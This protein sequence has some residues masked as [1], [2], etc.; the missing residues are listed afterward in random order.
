MIDKQTQ[1]ELRAR[2]NPDGSDLRRLQLYML[3]LLV[4]FDRI[5]RKNDID[6]WLEYGT[7]IGAARHGGFIPWDDDLDVTLLKKDRKKLIEA[8]RKDL[9]APYY[10]IDADSKE[11]D[12]RRWCKMR[13][14]N[15]LITRLV[16]NPSKK[17]ELIPKKEGIWLDIFYKI[18]GNSFLSFKVDAFYGRCFRRKNRLV[19]DGWFKHL[20]GV[21]LFPVAQLVAALARLYGK[22][23]LPGRLIN[24][25]GTD[26][27]S[28]RYIKDIYPLKD[29]EFEGHLFKAPNDTDHYLKVIYGNWDTVPEVKENHKITDIE[30]V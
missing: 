10:F 8:L 2:Y 30:V 23:F 17:G 27:H 14:D 26:F 18:N 19:D 28:Q 15:V 11:G 12:T 6:Y 3:D 4:E 25:Y 9:Q 22:I 24:D 29:I 5:C 7:L 13:N 20:T 1:E 16:E 21:I